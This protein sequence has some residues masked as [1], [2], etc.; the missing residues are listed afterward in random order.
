LVEGDDVHDPIGDA[1]RGI[2]DGHIVLSRKLANMG[3]YPAVDV[4]GSVSRVQ[5]AV[6]DPEHL[7]YA[8][9][10]RRLLSDYQDNEELRRLGAYVK[11]SDAAVDQAFEKKPHMD[12]FLR[13]QVGELTE[14]SKSVA[15]MQA[16]V[17]S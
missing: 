5:P 11:G 10:M 16:L 9:G 13:Q 15:F 17:A 14:C 1:V 8:Q 4:L 6:V 3:H 2:V 12:L 7:V